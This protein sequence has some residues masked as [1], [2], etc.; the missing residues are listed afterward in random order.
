MQIGEQYLRSHFNWWTRQ[1]TEK[2]VVV[3][4]HEC[5]THLVE[6]VAARMLALVAVRGPQIVSW[7]DKAC[8]I[9]Q[10]T[11]RSGE[12]DVE[13]LG[14]CLGRG[15]RVVSIGWAPLRSTCSKVASLRFRRSAIPE[16][17]LG[18]VII[19][20]PWW[21]F[22]S[23]IIHAKSFVWWCRACI[24]HF[25]YLFP[26]TARSE[27]NLSVP[28]RHIGFLYLLYPIHVHLRLVSQEFPLLSCSFRVVKPG[29]F[30][31]RILHPFTFRSIQ[32]LKPF[33]VESVF[34]SRSKGKPRLS[35]AGFIIWARPNRHPL[36]CILESED[37]QFNKVT[38]VGMPWKFVS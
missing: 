34:L 24:L 22:E 4:E 2:I 18:F 37:N 36:L 8:G 7:S 9:G 30:G 35:A 10:E 13:A 20:I 6:V 28:V 31:E 15:D 5:C 19:K 16:V 38:S 14:R 33:W 1:C 17:F 25:W 12:R 32:L 26:V 3:S 23:S 11:R 21:D 29:F 27:R